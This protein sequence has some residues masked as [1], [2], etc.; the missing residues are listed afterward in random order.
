MRGCLESFFFYYYLSVP[1]ILKSSILSITITQFMFKSFCVKYRFFI[2]P[3]V[4]NV[5]DYTFR[6]NGTLL[7]YKFC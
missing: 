7:R 2:L 6:Y 5:T 1:R 4:V 3:P